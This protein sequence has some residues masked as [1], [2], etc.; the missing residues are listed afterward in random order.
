MPYA[1]GCS[2]GEKKILVGGTYEKKSKALTFDC[3][4]NYRRATELS[5]QI[6]IW[7]KKDFAIVGSFAKNR[8]RTK[9]ADFTSVLGR[10]ATPDEYLMAYLLAKKPARWTTYEQARVEEQPE[11]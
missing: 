6:R 10:R 1:V 5:D 8:P 7:Q 11:L 9:M 2:I 4:C 3:S